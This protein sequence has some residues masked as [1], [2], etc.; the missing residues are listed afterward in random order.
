[1]DGEGKRH[2]TTGAQTEL[3]FTSQIVLPDSN[4]KY[5]VGS[6]FHHLS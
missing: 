2:H 4:H 3:G 1:M 6:G 5:N